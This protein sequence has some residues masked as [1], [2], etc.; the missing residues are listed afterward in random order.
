M[1]PIK[2]ISIEAFSFRVPIGTPIKV[3]FGTF[4]DRPFVLVRIVDADGTEGWGEVWCNWPAIG[5]KKRA[6]PWQTRR[7]TALSSIE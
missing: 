7:T 1:N 6:Q 5:K 4:R 2:P 3:A